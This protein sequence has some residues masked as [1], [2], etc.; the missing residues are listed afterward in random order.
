M[1]IRE[2][3]LQQSDISFE[4]ALEIVLAIESSKI[5]NKD[6]YKSLFSTYVNK[7]TNYYSKE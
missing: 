4:Q 7:I 5:E 3:I 6:T 1:V 2:N